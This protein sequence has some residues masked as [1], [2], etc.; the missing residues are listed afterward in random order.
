MALN[1]DR[2]VEKAI[3]DLYVA[4]TRKA[5]AKLTISLY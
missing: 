2:C 3:F 1:N 4:I 5:I